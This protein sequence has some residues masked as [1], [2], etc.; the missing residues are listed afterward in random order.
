MKNTMNYFVSIPQDYI[1][2]P[3]KVNCTWLGQFNKTWISP[4][5]F[6]ELSTVSFWDLIFC[7]L[8]S[9]NRFTYKGLFWIVFWARGRKLWIQERGKSG[10]KIGVE[11]NLYPGSRYI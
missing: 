6:M 3:L 2:S 5:I 4:G 8:L 7:Y 1:W 10:M 9:N 11:E